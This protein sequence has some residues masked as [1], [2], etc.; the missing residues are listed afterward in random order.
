MAIVKMK[1]LS[2]AAAACDADE[3]MQKLMWTG[4]VEVSDAAASLDGD[5]D[6]PPDERF[7]IRL[8]QL[9]SKLIGY[10]KAISFLKEYEKAPKG[11]F[12]KRKSCARTSYD[13]PE[14]TFSVADS[15][16]LEAHKI[17]S[18]IDDIFA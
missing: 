15:I 5:K 4:S 6:L 9:N 18:G 10:E 1:K 14:E 11:L 3:L 17:A 16:S 13:M 2:L 12:A 7:S 8:S